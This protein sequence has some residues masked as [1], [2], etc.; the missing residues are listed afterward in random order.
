M[1][2]RHIILTQSPAGVATLTL[3]RPDSLNA[4]T[5]GLLECSK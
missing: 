2:F 1:A 4:L 3:N 5:S